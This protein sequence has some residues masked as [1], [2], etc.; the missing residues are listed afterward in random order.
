M[1]LVGTALIIA[2]YFAPPEAQTNDGYQLKLFLY[3]MGGAFAGSTLI[4]LAFFLLYSF[5]RDRKREYLKTNGRRGEAEIS[6][7]ELTGVIVAGKP[8]FKLLLRV[9]TFDRPPFMI[10]YSF[11]ADAEEIRNLT[12]GRKLTIYVDKENAKN[13]YVEIP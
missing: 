7:T 1:V 10:S 11:F 12:V 3:I 5:F 8:Q 9:W 6:K 4:F 13:V 2:A